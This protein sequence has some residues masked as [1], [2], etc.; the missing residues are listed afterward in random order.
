[1]IMILALFISIPLTLLLIYFTT[2]LYKKGFKA[3][4]E[5]SQPL[6]KVLF[7]MLYSLPFNIIF[8]LYLTGVILS[9][10]HEL[11]KWASISIIAIV[12][13]L[14]FALC[15]GTI[16]AVLPLMLLINSHDRDDL[17]R[18]TGISSSFVD[19]LIVFTLVVVLTFCF[20]FYKFRK[21][22]SEPCL[23]ENNMT[24]RIEVATTEAPIPFYANTLA[25]RGLIII[26]HFAVI[27][28]AVLIKALGGI[29]LSHLGSIILTFGVAPILA[30]YSAQLSAKAF[31]INEE[32]ASKAVVRTI[33]LSVC[34]ISFLFCYLTLG[35]LF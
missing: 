22:K 4:Q 13:T 24:N 3:V 19:I 26:L 8:S 12:I 2:S 30:I 29:Y 11:G 6:R 31:V 7:L 5:I 28:I 16:Y 34:A 18:M 25:R 14:V 35:A 33:F 27:F 15:F 1:M 23:D 32:T 10:N 20:W 17:L 21:E 9:F